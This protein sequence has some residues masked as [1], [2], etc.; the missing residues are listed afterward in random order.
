MIMGEIALSF[1]LRWDIEISVSS[2]QTSTI[3]QFFFNNF[4]Y[5]F[6]WRSRNSSD[7][8]TIKPYVL[9]LFIMS[10]LHLVEAFAMRE[11]SC[12]R[13]WFSLD[14]STI[15]FSKAAIFSFI[16]RQNHFDK[17]IEKR[18][19]SSFVFNSATERIRRVVRGSK[20]IIQCRLD[21]FSAPLVQRL[22]F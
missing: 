13:N 2:I 5:I 9:F 12:L 18:K 3:E 16:S 21:G 1:L 8:Q 14:N 4:I 17:S 20:H 19:D 6:A 11:F 10:R 22:S 15:V 7:F